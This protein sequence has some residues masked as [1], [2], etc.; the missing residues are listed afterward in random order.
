MGKGFQIWKPFI[1]DL[2]G[3]I[4]QLFHLSLLPG[5]I[6]NNNQFF[7]KNLEPS[8]FSITSRHSLLLIGSYE[9][10]QFV[11]ALGYLYLFF[12]LIYFKFKENLF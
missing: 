7:E 12:Y 8:N 6:Y 1:K 3:L 9:P 10:K 2:D 4:S 11:S 5:F